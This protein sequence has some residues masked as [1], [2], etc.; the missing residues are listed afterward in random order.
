[1]PATQSKFYLQTSVEPNRW[2]VVTAE[3]VDQAILRLWCESFGAVF[4]KYA[5][6]DPATLLAT[7]TKLEADRLPVFES[8]RYHLGQES[9]ATE[10]RASQAYLMANQVV[11]WLTYSALVAKFGDARA[12]KILWGWIDDGGF[13]PRHLTLDQLSDQKKETL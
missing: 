1:M 12:E 11:Q 6:V 2:F 4:E 8:Y 3:N 13:K 5:R 10:H 9:E 7:Y